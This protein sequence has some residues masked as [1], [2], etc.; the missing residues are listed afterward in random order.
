MRTQPGRI[1]PV[2]TFALTDLTVLV[3][4]Y[5]TPLLLRACLRRLRRHAA[6]AHL[7]VVE[8]GDAEETS[9]LLRAFPGVALLR[10]ANH[11]LAHAVNE[12]LKRCETRVAA[13]I[14]AD[15]LVG[16]E[17]FGRLLGVLGTARTGMVGP[18]PLTPRG[19]VQDQGLPYRLH[20]WRLARRP[21]GAALGVSWLAGCLQVV[22]MEA[23]LAVGGMD[24]SLRFYNEDIDW[25]WRLRRA[26]WHCRLVNS[27]VLHLGGSAT[28]ARPD[29]LLE[30]YRG[31][32][33][34]SQRYRGRGY[35]WLHRR[36]VLAQSFWEARCGKDPLR[37]E[38]F[39]RI[40]RMF[41]QG[42]FDIS[43][44]GDSLETSD[45]AFLGGP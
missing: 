31:G 43:P 4:H 37:R 11:S 8:S 19:S 14:N 26:G 7:V 38:A 39:A 24:P 1:G 15:V 21:P 32:Y 44:F 20:T 16:E 45:P 40:A 9:E 3:I 29:F 34:L 22:R 27:P 13:H 5:R 25:S 23:V 2:N 36:A 30:G 35:R 28:P 17:T 6:G 42:R 12:G 33:K 10:V 41:R 18:L